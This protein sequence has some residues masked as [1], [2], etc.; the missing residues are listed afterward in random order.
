M[1][2]SQ[3]EIQSLLLIDL[4]PHALYVERGDGYEVII[5]KGCPIPTRKTIEFPIEE[6]QDRLNVKVYRKKEDEDYVVWFL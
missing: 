3:K 5:P 1:G 2:L 6:S 4:L